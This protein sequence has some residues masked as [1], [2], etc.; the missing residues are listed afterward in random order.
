MRRSVCSVEA[1]RGGPPEGNSETRTLKDR[2]AA[3]AESQ[4]AGAQ[5][6]AQ[7]RQVRDGEVVG[8]QTS[9]P[10]QADD[11]VGDVEEDG[12]LR[13]RGRRRSNYPRSNRVTTFVR[14]SVHFSRIQ[15]GNIGL[16]KKRLY[17]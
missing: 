9:P 13:R 10:H 14:I 12:H 17:F 6:V 16:V 15:T 2:H 5:Q 4:E 7:R 11:E 1:V 8:V 3:E